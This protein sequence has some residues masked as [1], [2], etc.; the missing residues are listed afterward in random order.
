MGRAFMAGQAP[1]N[2]IETPGTRAI[3]PAREESVYTVEEIAFACTRGC[4]RSHH[5]ETP[6]RA[7]FASDAY[8]VG[9]RPE[10]C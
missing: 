5:S 3:R 8:E 2:V 1:G 9:Q 10:T 4:N 7:Y 6:G